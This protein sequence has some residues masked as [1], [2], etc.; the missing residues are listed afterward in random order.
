MAKE[1]EV[2]IVASGETLRTVAGWMGVAEGELDGVMER[3][4]MNPEFEAGRTQGLGLGAKFLP[5]HKAVAL[6]SGVEHRLIGKLK[7]SAAH[8]SHTASVRG[9]QGHQSAAGQAHTRSWGSQQQQAPAGAGLLGGHQ[10]AEEDSEED[11]DGRGQAFSKGRQSGGSKS[12]GFSR[13]D[14]LALSGNAVAP[15]AGK[16]KK[17]RKNSGS[18]VA[19]ALTV[20]ST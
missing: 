19:G 1:E 20:C 3:E 16:K 8:V 2:D 17:K 15:A 10:E 12:K 11:V 4:G 18:G 14:W 6:T 13:S 7:R 5:H 9:H